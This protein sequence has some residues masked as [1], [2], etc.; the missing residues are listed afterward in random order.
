MSWKDA[1][2]PSAEPNIGTIA[3][4]RLFIQSPRTCGY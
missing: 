2:N 1:G 4:M 3:D